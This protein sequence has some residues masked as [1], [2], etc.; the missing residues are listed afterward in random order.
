MTHGV[1]PERKMILS[2][3]KRLWT[4]WWLPKRKGS[5]PGIPW[6]MRKNFPSMDVCCMKMNSALRRIFLI[7]FL[8]AYGI[9]S[10]LFLGKGRKAIR[11]SAR[12]F[13]AGR[14][15]RN[16]RSCFPNIFLPLWALTRKEVLWPYRSIP[17]R[18]FCLPMM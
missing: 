6:R 8:K 1:L 10:F 4:G 17:L 7:L 5:L 15:L 3:L 14:L 11:I 16:S 12:I 18:I 9:R 2:S 13:S